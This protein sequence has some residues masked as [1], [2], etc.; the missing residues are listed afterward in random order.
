MP[1]YFP[2][3]QIT[4]GASSSL[5]NNVFLEKSFLNRVYTA[6]ARGIFIIETEK[7]KNNSNNLVANAAFSKIRSAATSL[8][9]NVV[10]LNPSFANY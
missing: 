1:T 3:K 8:K 4:N 9:L 2:P 6:K 7:T 10:L 5:L